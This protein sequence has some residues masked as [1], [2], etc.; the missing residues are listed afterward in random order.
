MFHTQDVIFPKL[1]HKFNKYVRHVNSVNVVLFPK[2]SNDTFQW[3]ED[4]RSSLTCRGS[5]SGQSSLSDNILSMFYY[6][7][8]KVMYPIYPKEITMS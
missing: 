1:K 8:Q 4:S 2:N 7:I 3:D 6:K 5:V